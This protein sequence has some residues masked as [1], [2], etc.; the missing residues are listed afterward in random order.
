[1]LD[2]RFLIT[3]LFT[4]CLCTLQVDRDS[5]LAADINNSRGVELTG[6]SLAQQVIIHRDE[7]GVAHLFG[8]TD[9]STLFGVGYAQAEDY[10]WQLEDT[11][12][13]AI[14]RYA[15][16]RGKNGLK[17]DLL[18]RSFELAGRSQRDFAKLPSESQE[19]LQAFAAGVNYFLEVDSTVKP[20]LLERFEAWHVLAIDRYLMLTMT[21]G[22]SGARK[23]RPQDAKLSL[24]DQDFPRYSWDW[25]DPPN[26][27]ETNVREAIGSNSWAIAPQKTKSGEAMLFINPHQPWYGIGQ[28][29]EMHLHSKETLRFSGACFFGNPIPVLGHNE[30]LGWA[31]TVN[32]PDV[33]DSWKIEFNHPQDPLK[34][35]FGEGYRRA[36]EWTESI[37]ILENNVLGTKTVTFRK[38][39]VGPVMS[40]NGKQAVVAKV[41]RLHDVGRLDQ[42]VEMVRATNFKEWK[43]A[44]SRCSIP[45][46]NVTYADRD[47]NIFYAYNGAVPI[48]NE[49]FDWTRTVDGSDPDTQWKG[50]HSFEDLP[51]VLNPQSGYVQNC[52]CSPYVTTDSGNPQRKN[53]PKYM[54]RD[55][56]VDKRRS[57]LA[58][59]L[60]S[61]AEKVSFDWYQQLCFDPTLYWPRIEKAN[62]QRDF[63]QL[64]KT[65]PEIAAK[66]KP[67]I[68]ALVNWDGKADKNSKVAL[69]C[70]SWYEELYGTS[71]SERIKS[72][73]QGNAREQL[74]A[75]GRVARRL[76]ELHG[77]WQL[78]WGE[79]HRLQRTAYSADTME[80]GVSL[81]PFAASQPC[82]GAP[83]PLGVVFTIYSTPS[84]PLL[85]PQRFAVVG[86][87]Y[88]SAIAFGKDR[89]RAVSLVPF[90]ASGSPRSP[91]FRD[92]ADLLANQK[93]KQAWFYEEDV[94]K[95]ARQSYHPGE[96]TKATRET[97]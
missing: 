39:E 65:D 79:V 80:A 7:W 12:I 75:L 29:Y 61:N 68:E 67:Y 72:E 9:K 3:L 4:V 1:M 51:Q 97:K 10:F 14:G 76:K 86:C 36:T 31:Y 57:K 60:L 95:A 41:A 25:V 63:K 37:S 23:P 20:R 87:S 34:Y 52:N 49:Q 83:G 19:L 78:P 38:T 90:G 91:H 82:A 94:K 30:N 58:R 46:F 32:Q 59:E 11:T 89:V 54:V 42:A 56:D 77:D 17:T 28:F 13:Q 22:G 8:E 27:L 53:F 93:F 96:K 66:L 74:I 85:R 69:L 73:Y 64:E 16:I 45:M 71:Q 43:K 70:I 62:W 84:V 24:Q 6:S 18:A 15:E 33:A 81:L 5:V 55:W 47:G 50:I 2:I 35:R 88:M 44:F 21:Y 48:R 92:Q 40:Y 26:Q